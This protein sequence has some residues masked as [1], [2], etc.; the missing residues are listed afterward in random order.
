MFR[1]INGY[2]SWIIEQTIEKVKNRNE[3]TRSAQVATDTEESEHLLMLPYEGKVGETTLKSLWN[4]LKSVIPTNNTCKIIYTGTKLASKFNIKDKIIKERK[5]DLCLDLNCDETYVGEIGRRFSER[6]IIIIN[7]FFFVGIIQH[8]KILQIVFRPKKLIK[9]NYKPS[10]M[11]V[12]KDTFL[13]SFKLHI[14]RWELKKKKRPN[15][16]IFVCTHKHTYA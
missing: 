6:I 15:S 14:Y 4:T 11:K 9:A 10:I 5:H 16:H 13:Q 1:D 3:M 2:P 8:F 12:L 7:N